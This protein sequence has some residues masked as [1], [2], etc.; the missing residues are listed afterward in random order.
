MIS[1]LVQN[2]KYLSIFAYYW[3]YYVHKID[4]VKVLRPTRHKLGHFEDI[5]QANLLA[6]YGK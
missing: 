3:L 2:W 5:L 4:S 1:V 6:W